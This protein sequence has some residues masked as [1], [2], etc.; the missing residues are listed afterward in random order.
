MSTDEIS[1]EYLRMK[2]R[3]YDSHLL[4]DKTIYDLDFDKILETIDKINMRREIK[5]ERDVF[6][7]LNK[8]ELSL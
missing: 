2:N 7:F 1:D 6:S 4:Y 8:F 5:I 3:S